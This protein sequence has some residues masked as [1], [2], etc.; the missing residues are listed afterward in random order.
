MLK[1]TINF[2]ESLLVS[3][4]GLMVLGLLY[5]SLSAKERRE[6]KLFVDDL[7]AVHKGKYDYPK[8]TTEEALLESRR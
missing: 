1:V 4:A 2:L 7:D 6:A 5:L 3:V 8:R